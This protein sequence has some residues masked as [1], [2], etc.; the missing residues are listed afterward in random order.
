MRQTKI[1]GPEQLI[2]K[3][4]KQPSKIGKVNSAH[5]KKRILLAASELF[6]LGGISAPVTYQHLTLPTYYSV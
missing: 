3:V 2:E 4:S 6:A 5:A 1:K